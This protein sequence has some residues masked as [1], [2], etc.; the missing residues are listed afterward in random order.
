[1]ASSVAPMLRRAAAGSS[2]RRQSASSS[3]GQRS[4]FPICTATTECGGMRSKSRAS[5]TA[6]SSMLQKVRSTSPAGSKDRRASSA[7]REGLL[8]RRRGAGFR[9]AF[10]SRKI[11]G[12]F[13]CESGCARLAWPT[14]FPSHES[15]YSSRL[16]RDHDLLR[17]RHDLPHPL[18]PSA[19]SRSA[20]A[21][22]ATR[23]SPASRSSSIPPAASRN[24]PAVT[25]PRRAARRRLARQSEIFETVKMPRASSPF[26]FAQS[27]QC[28]SQSRPP[29]FHLP[30]SPWTSPHSSPA[31]PT[32]S[33]NSKPRFPSG[34]SLRRS[35]QGAGDPARTHPAEGTARQLGAAAKSAHR[36]GRKPGTGQGRGQGMAEMAAAEIPAL[37][38]RIADTGAR[39]AVR[40]AAARPE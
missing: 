26:S 31:K 15:R 37:E 24:S 5:F 1:M 40:A 29:T 38:K 4:L 21:P 22:P 9:E 14:P 28:R 17:V 16:P 11:V 19:T 13:D 34:E 30:P 7:P 27:V 20:S 3:S 6:S 35:A 36:A 2:F 33:A 18:A 39:R 25:A 10:R 32:A 8:A 12:V 23:S